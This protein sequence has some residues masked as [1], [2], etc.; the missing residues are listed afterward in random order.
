MLMR[1]FTY[2]G[3]LVSLSIKVLAMAARS[4]FRKVPLAR[5]RR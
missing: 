3:G 5:A 1:V 4:F 2:L